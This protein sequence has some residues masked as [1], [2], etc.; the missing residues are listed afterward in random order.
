MYTYYGHTYHKSLVQNEHD[1]D[2]PKQQ[3]HRKGQDEGEKLHP[4]ILLHADDSRAT[5]KHHF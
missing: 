1:E 3:Q 2:S 5:G 4:L